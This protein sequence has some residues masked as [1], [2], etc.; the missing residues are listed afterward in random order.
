MRYVLM[1]NSS[2]KISQIYRKVHVVEF[3]FVKV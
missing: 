3:V 2:E 1:N